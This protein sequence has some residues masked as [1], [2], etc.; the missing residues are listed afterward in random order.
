MR[1]PITLF[2]AV[3]CLAFAL[4]CGDGPDTPEPVAKGAAGQA[5]AASGGSGGAAGSAGAGMFVGGPGGSTSN[6]CH[7]SIV[8]GITCNNVAPHTYCKL[9][10]GAGLCCNP[11]SVTWRNCLRN[12]VEVH[13]A[14]RTA[15]VRKL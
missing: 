5:G 9:P 14:P 3:S 8:E 4:A 13:Q 1:S 7:P 10:S 2:A 11:V 12:L 6:A 15:D